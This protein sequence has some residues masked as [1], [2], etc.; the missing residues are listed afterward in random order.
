MSVVAEQQ[1]LRV[2]IADDVQALRRLVRFVLE[3]A[4]PF[5]VVGEAS[6]GEEA[7][8]VIAETRPDLVLLDLSMPRMDGL[9]AL[10]RIRAVAPNARVV[11][12]SGFTS[13]KMGEATTR[14]GA[15]GYL[16]KGAKPSEIVSCLLR[17]AR[18]EP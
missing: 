3:D 1:Q 9:E 13:D 18:G 2:V 7:V 5:A 16:E 6:D 14:L 11:V 17:A 8:R 12:F 4:G 10:P 15:A